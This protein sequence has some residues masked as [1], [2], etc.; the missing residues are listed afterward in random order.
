MLHARTVWV[1]GGLERAVG[2]RHYGLDF[3]TVLRPSLVLTYLEIW[4]LNLDPHASE[5][6]LVPPSTWRRYDPKVL[7]DLKG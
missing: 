5:L 6:S 4:M 7:F 2:V 1:Q 3:K